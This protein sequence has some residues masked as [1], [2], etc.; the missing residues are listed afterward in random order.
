VLIKINIFKNLRNKLIFFTNNNLI[1]EREDKSGEEGES[2]VS[3]T[4][5]NF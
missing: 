2:L 3:E 4:M 1:E 5:N